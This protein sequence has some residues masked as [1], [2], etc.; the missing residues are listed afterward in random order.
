[1]FR[2]ILYG[3]ATIG[4]CY[5]VG[6]IGVLIYVYILGCRWRSIPISEP[7]CFSQTGGAESAG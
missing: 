5:T 6:T 4:G 1:M 2:V 3:L 7:D